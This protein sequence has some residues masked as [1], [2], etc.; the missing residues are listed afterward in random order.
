MRHP[1]CDVVLADFYLRDMSGPEVALVC[2]QRFP[3]IRV[4][5]MK[6]SPEPLDEKSLEV[7]R[8]AHPSRQDPRPSDGAGVSPWR[9]P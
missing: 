2:R 7:S 1:A 4:G 5:V 8:T 6:R 3:D 9:S